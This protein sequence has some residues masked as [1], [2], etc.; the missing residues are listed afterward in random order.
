MTR[1]LAAIPLIVLLALGWLFVAFGLRRDPHISPAA[2]VGHP[3]PARRLPPLGGG[4]PVALSS[5]VRGVTVI[6][7]F[8][9]TCVPCIEEAPALLALKAEGA[10]LVGV[11]YKDDAV[12]AGAF[13]ARYGDPFQVVLIDQDGRAGVDLGVSGVPETFLVRPDGVVAAKFIGALQPKDAVTIL[14]M[15]G[16][17]TR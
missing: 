5:Q 1:L 13:L 4:A 2:L 11:A 8:S 15:T 7:T 10:R 6:N 12:H 3:I 14:E 9:S 17:P 16:S